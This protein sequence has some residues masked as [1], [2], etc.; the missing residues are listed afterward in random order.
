MGKRA[1]RA[2]SIVGWFF[3]L[4]S[5][6]SVADSVAPEDCHL[7]LVAERALLAAIRED[8]QNVSTLATIPDELTGVVTAEPSS[9]FDEPVLPPHGG[10]S[11]SPAQ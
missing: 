6:V 1:H 5:L 9:R 11:D 2:P 4:P 10:P 7:A 8:A 3:P